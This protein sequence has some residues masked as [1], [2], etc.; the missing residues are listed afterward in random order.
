MAQEGVNGLGVSVG[1]LGARHGHAGDETGLLAGGLAGGLPLPVEV[2]GH[3][4][5]AV[6]GLGRGH[7]GLGQH[8]HGARTLGQGSHALGVLALPLD[9]DVGVG[10]KARLAQ[11]VLQRILGRGALAGGVDGASAQVGDGLDLV[12][13][14]AD[15]EHA[16]R[17]DGDDVHAALGLVVE[18]ARE[19]CR[20]GGHVH[21]GLC[22]ERGDL[23]GGG[24]DL[25]R[26]V[27]V[28]QVAGVGLAHE[29]HQAHGRRA[30]EGGGA[31]GDGLRSRFGVGV[32]G[33]RGGVVA[34]RAGAAG[35]ADR[36]TA[37]GRRLQELS[38]VQHV[39][40]PSLLR[41]APRLASAGPFV[42][43]AAAAAGARRP[44]GFVPA[45]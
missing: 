44:C 22:D 26:P 24:Q 16:Q 15:V 14:L 41:Y 31:D 17:V 25:E 32:P 38:S 1:E 9:G 37:Q 11:H 4:D 13:Q 5:L 21:L 29:A 42:K 2:Q 20:H 40:L 3:A 6:L 36:S 34:R 35:K 23:V 45:F 10:V 7:E 8:G 19:V 18:H 39:M 27:L 43:W 12:S 30:L 28:G 33:G